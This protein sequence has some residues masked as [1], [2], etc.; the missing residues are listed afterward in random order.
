MQNFKINF[1]LLPAY[2]CSHTVFQFR[3]SGPPLHYYVVLQWEI[4]SQCKAQIPFLV[5]CLGQ[6]FFHIQF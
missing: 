5:K 4:H 1:N 6:L 3:S 2:I